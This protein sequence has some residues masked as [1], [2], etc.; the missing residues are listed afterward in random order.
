MHG[1]CCGLDGDGA[2]KRRKRYANRIQ[3]SPGW[4]MVGHIRNR[5]KRLGIT[6]AAMVACAVMHVTDEQLKTW[7]PPF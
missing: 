4:L 7:G 3:V 2:M 6:P 1:G 5:A